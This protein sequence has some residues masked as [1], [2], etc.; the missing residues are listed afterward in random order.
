[1]VFACDGMDA[2]IILIDSMYFYGTFGILAA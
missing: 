2:S 1:M